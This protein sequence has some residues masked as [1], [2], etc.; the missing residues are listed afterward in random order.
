MPIDVDKL[1]ILRSLSVAMAELDL[2]DVNLLM[3][4]AGTTE[5]GWTQWYGDGRWDVT[6]SERAVD[7]VEA[8]R[9]LP[10]DVL[11]DLQSAAQ[12]LFALPPAIAELRDPQPLT[13]FASHLAKQR[14][15]VGGVGK[16]LE[17]WGIKLFVAH[18]SIE[19]DTD[20]QN[21]IE[22]ALDTS[23]AGLVFLSPGFADS[24]WCDQEVGWLLGRKL[25][26]L[27]LKFQ[28]QDP[29][30]PLGRKQA[31]VIRDDMTAASI[32][33][34]TMAWL[35]GKPAL[36]G[37]LNASLVEALKA[38]SQYSR[39]DQI[40]DKLHRA[41]DL[42][43]TQVAGILAA[44]RDNDQVYNA[45]HRGATGDDACGYA[46]LAF[47]LAMLQPGWAANEELAR[48]VAHMRHLEQ[49]IPSTEPKAVEPVWDNGDAPF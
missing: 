5:F 36:A 33:D 15:L 32:A 37:S 16:A 39:T 47:K 49:L 13:I 41:Q 46:E 48:E 3:H 2:A 6:P 25:P 8:M 11:R 1:R 45:S 30:G 22:R 40:W 38:S 18:D 20:W 21:E 23:S 19:P 10:H 12:D 27:P 4:E 28:G 43:A 42:G 34:L 17:I 7:L 29:Y 24:K 31:N 35:E 9:D 26:C 44:I 14:K